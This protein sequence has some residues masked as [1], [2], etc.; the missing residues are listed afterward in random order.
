VVLGAWWALIFHLSHD[1]EGPKAPGIFSWFIIS[2]NCT[3]FTW[4]KSLEFWLFVSWSCT[5]APNLPMV[6]VSPEEPTSLLVL[7][8][9][10]PCNWKPWNWNSW[11]VYDARLSWRA[12]ISACPEKPANPAGTGKPAMS[13][14]PFS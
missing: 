10:Q 11:L 7:K 13:I 2:W 1:S 6:P 14:S 5:G 12:N 3:N 8:S 9:L 4:L